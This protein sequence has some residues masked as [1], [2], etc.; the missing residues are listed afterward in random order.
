MTYDGF[1]KRATGHLPYSY[2]TRLANDG[3]PEA[4]AV[5]TGAGKTAAVIVAWL[6]R[7]FETSPSDTAR[8]LVIMLPLRT[9]VEQTARNAEEWRQRL[10]LGSRVRIIVLMGG[11]ATAAELN[12][13]RRNPQLP[14]IIIG[15]VD[16]VLSRALVRG[17]AQPRPSYPIDFALVTDDAHWVIDEVQLAAQATA[18]ARQLDAFR[19]QLQVMHPGRLTC[20]SATLPEGPLDTIDNPYTA[21][22]VTLS[23]ADRV[24]PLARRLDATREISH[25]ESVKP[26]EIAAAIARDHRPG[27]L[28]LAVINTVAAATD[29]AKR[30]R[31]LTKDV[32]VT[33]LHSRFRGVDRAPLVRGL[34]APLP[35]AGRIVISTQ[36]VE[37]G[38]DLDAATLFTELA[39]WSSLCQRAGRCNRAGV[40]DGARIR[41]FD[42]LGKGP[43]EAEDLTAAKDALVA[44]GQAQVTSQDLLGRDVDQTQD[45]LNILRRRDF[46]RLFDTSPDLSGA[47]I[48]VSMFIRPTE[49]V[50]ITVAWVEADQLKDGHLA[51]VPTDPWRCSI[52]INEARKWLGRPGGPK[53]WTYDPTQSRWRELPPSRVSTL[54]PNNLLLVDRQGGGYAPAVGF[55]PASTASVSI[56]TDHTERQRKPVFEGAAQGLADDDGSTGQ[57]GWQ[58]LDDHLAAAG[59]QAASL[60]AALAPAALEPGVR[61]AVVAAAT[62]HDL[63]KAFPDWQRALL[64][65][66]PSPP[67]GQGPWAK[68]PGRDR[69]RVASSE[70]VPRRGFRH[71]LVSVIQLSTPVG[72]EALERAGVPEEQHALTVYL[73]G[74][75]HG[76]LRIQPRDPLVEGRHGTSLMGLHDGEMIPSLEANGVKFP[77]TEVDLSI[78]GMGVPQSWSRRSLDLLAAWGPF[79]L[80]WMEMVVRMSDWRSSA[81][82]ARVKE[83]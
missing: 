41:W 12:E 25:L 44:L 19:A 45:L 36:V 2:Q 63:G 4:L 35:S 53:A 24:G 46:A 82:D 57:V 16:S 58:R 15:T 50:D 66:N 31:K 20:M 9:L 52:P 6:F 51:E 29:I 14:T 48:D 34:T 22:A 62:F 64:A 17:Y 71:E 28:T 54:R 72:R 60:L 38:V 67:A 79:R 69:L 55:D 56:E 21:E 80:A 59:Q 30:V 23:E 49:D 1:F 74:A 27:T 8:T 18:T 65:A 37:A 40:T 70:D 3:L 13:W 39:P 11:S 5:P 78:F 33:L 61:A 26:A 42:T 83:A 73:V 43:Y 47:D 77:E 75:H 7:R 76:H 10:G 68:S 81:G 32:D